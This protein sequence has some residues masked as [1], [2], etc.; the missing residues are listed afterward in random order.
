L[1]VT[2]KAFGL[3]RFAR[4]DIYFFVPLT[5]VSSR[6]VKRRGNPYKNKNLQKNITAHFAEN[7][8]VRKS[9]IQLRSKSNETRD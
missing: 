7:K 1:F 3:L 2:V 4:N 5:S 6:G 8:A 9:Q